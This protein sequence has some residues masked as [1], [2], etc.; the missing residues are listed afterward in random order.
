MKADLPS[1][2]KKRKRSKKNKS[3]IQKPGILVF[4]GFCLAYLTLPQLVIIISSG[5]ENFFIK[6]LALLSFIINFSNTF[7]SAV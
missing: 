1:A 4:P 2:S 7:K 6:A 5:D 3:Y